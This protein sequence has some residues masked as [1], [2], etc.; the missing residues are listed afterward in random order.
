MNPIQLHTDVAFYTLFTSIF[1]TN[2]WMIP[3]A[4]LCTVYVVLGT[5]RSRSLAAAALVPF[6]CLGISAFISLTVPGVDPVH[7]DSISVVSNIVY[8][9][10]AAI[11]IY[12]SWKNI[13][14]WFSL[15]RLTYIRKQN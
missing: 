13:R 1:I 14:R 12:E 5:N 8:D 15:R 9:G 7:T 4:C 3:I 6:I 11:G 2:A 10:L